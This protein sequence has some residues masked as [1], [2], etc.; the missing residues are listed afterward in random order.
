M[1]MMMVL[2]CL[3]G[4]MVVLLERNKFMSDYELMP[5]VFVFIISFYVSKN[6][7]TTDYYS[8]FIKTQT[9]L[10]LTQ[11]HVARV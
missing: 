1:I 9:K 10:M 4:W 6:P 7:M 11:S 5:S 8:Y 2:V 3:L